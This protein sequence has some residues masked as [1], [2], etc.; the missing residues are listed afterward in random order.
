MVCLWVHYRTVYIICIHYYAD[1]GAGTVYPSGAHEF[2]YGFQWG[3]CYSIFSFMCMFCRSLFVLLAIVLSVLW[4]LQTLLVCPSS[5]K[6]FILLLKTFHVRT[7]YLFHVRD[8]NILKCQQK[9]YN[10]ILNQLCV[11]RNNNLHPFSSLPSLHSFLLLHTSVW[12]MHFLLV[13]H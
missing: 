13:L 9:A 3:S 10:C 5:Y 8:E 4:Y 7:K 2:T 6:I 1:S 12:D 11:I